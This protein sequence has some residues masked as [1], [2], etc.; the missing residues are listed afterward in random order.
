VQVPA[1][2]DQIGP[3]LRDLCEINESDGAGV[4]R[5][6]VIR[7]ISGL[8]SGFPDDLKLA[9]E[10][11]LGMNTAAQDKF[12]T[13]RLAWLA[14]RANRDNRTIARRVDEALIRLCEAAFMTN[15]RQAADL[16]WHLQRFDAVLRLN[17]A[18]PIS[19]EVRTIVADQDGVDRVTWS[20]SVPKTAEDAPNAL[21]VDVLYGAVV[22][23]KRRPSGQRFLLDLQLPETLRAGRTHQYA[24]E[25]RIPPGQAMRPTYVFW[26]E[27]RCD[28]FNLT[29]RFATDHLPRA[30][31]RV[32]DVFHRDADDMLPTE[33]LLTVNS[34]GSVHATFNAPR[35][36]RGHGI[37]WQF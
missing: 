34:T 1:I 20:M 9:L 3:V 10:T 33:D 5:E 19:T 27:R 31:W 37:Q 7:W 8:A 35:I 24:I 11:A 18:T 15:T 16:P 13:D 14:E 23:G 30:V 32:R 26:P 28:V 25:A 29:I 12:Y 36:A 22:I 6:K 4:A 2:T 17:G 21:E